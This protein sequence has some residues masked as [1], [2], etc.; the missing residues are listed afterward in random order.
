MTFKV[1][2][3]LE[4]Y[5]ET[6]PVKWSLL[7]QDYALSWMLYGLM[8]VP[9]LQE[10]LVFKGG[11]CLKKC[12]FGDYR[13]S[14]DLDF[15]V[16]GDCPTGDILESLIGYACTIATEV[17]QATK[18][19]ITFTCK[20]YI[21]KRPHPEQQ[22]AF[23][24]LIQYPWQRESL[25]R[26][27]IEITLSEIVFMPPQLLDLIHGYGDEVTAQ[28][29]AYTLEEIIAEKIA[30]LISFSKKLHERG[31]GRSRARDYYDLWRIF[32]SYQEQIQ[33][34]LILDLV[35]KKCARKNLIFHRP[36][37]IFA[38]NLMEDLDVAWDEWVKPLVVN[39]PKKELVIRELKFVLQSL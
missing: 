26:I 33:T 11:T 20:R 35:A 7:E 14:Q 24:I 2:D 16:Q 23:S 8:S 31:W 25:T 39:L 10:H 9:K 15:S 27:M 36:E 30:A 6:H 34:S 19:N 13:F 29:Q 22:E 5:I 4:K 38:Q 3:L 17:L 28:I 32:S 37:D 18:N 21:E 12:Y 1:R